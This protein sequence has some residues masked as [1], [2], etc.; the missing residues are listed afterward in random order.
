MKV[1]LTGGTGFIGSHFI[2]AAMNDEIDILALKRSS[3]SHCRIEL[4]KEPQWLKKKYLEVESSDLVGC[5]VFVHLAAHSANVPY[6]S[7][8]N[9]IQHNVIEPIV[10][11]RKAIAAG[12]KKFI[13][14]GSCFEYGRSGERYENIPIDAPLEPTMSY[15][16]SKAAATSAFHALACEEMLEMQ[17]LRI[18][19]IYGEG[20]VAT[21]FWP[22]LRNAATKGE[23]FEMTDGK[24]VRDFIHVSQVAREFVDAIKMTTVKSGE[25]VIR[26]LGT[27]KPMSLLEFAS[28]EWKDF[29]ATG[30][31][32]VGA[33]KQRN[34]EVMRF[35]PEIDDK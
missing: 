31:L 5:E 16:C 6:D 12:I 17:F 20:E 13:I 29:N 1:F 24:Q 22:S 7:V 18:F 9:C 35:V 11:F 23:D 28:R 8:E 10:L 4:S 27:G 14:A 33:K 34:N 26:N 15:P 2:E 32:V 25:P 30:K 19:Q 3:S 21:R